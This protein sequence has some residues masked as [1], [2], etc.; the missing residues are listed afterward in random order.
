M[1]FVA[2][3]TDLLRELTLLQGLAL[4]T[5]SFPILSH[6]WLEADADHV[7]FA[8]TN[9][10]VGMR[11]A[12][13]ATVTTPGVLTL[14]ARAFYDIVRSFPDT[15]I[16]VEANQHGATVT[17][18]KFDGHM[19]ALP[20]GDFPQLPDAEVAPMASIDR[21]S[22]REM[23]GKVLF[24]MSADDTRYFL[25]GAQLTLTTEDMRMVAT[26]GHR[27]AVVTKPRVG[28]PEIA[29]IQ[30]LLSRK[31]LTELS[32]LLAD[33]LALETFTYGKTAEHLFF[34]VGDRLLIARIIDA[35]F[36]N[37][38]KV[39]PSDVPIRLELNRDKLVQAVRRV[40]ILADGRTRAVK[41]TLKK[42]KLEINAASAER[43]EAAEPLPVD[44]TAKKTL[45]I[46]FNAQYLLEGLAACG[47]DGVSLECKD[48][49]T[50]VLVKPIAPQGFDYTYVLMPMRT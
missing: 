42:N 13:P 12:C 23:V 1:E 24:A 3:K 38:D 17:A 28:G 6:V 8:A 36:P 37:Y 18:E 2:R 27:L 26:D 29:T 41:L 16:H 15:D 47:T 20:A 31:T 4:P 9:L 19:I 32:R 46:C 34:H 50:Q 40:A 5:P 45:T 48:D 14:P 39:I 21:A 10:E 11:S 7:K 25:N 49:V 33:P 44:Y 43:G 30:T 22:I 35:Q